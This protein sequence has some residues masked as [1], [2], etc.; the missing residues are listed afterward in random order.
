[1]ADQPFLPLGSEIWPTRLFILRE[2]VFICLMDSWFGLGYPA[3]FLASFLAAT[4]LPFSSEIILSS[5][6]MAGYSLWGCVITASIGNWLGGITSFGLGYL[7]RWE[8]LEK[9]FGIKRERM[10]LFRQRI[11]RY[12]SLLAF[13]TWLPFVGDVLAVALGF[14]R[15]NV[16]RSIAWMLVGKTLRYVVWGLFTHLWI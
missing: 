5:M 4:V 9:Y 6:L 10:E 16:P 12:G 13:F 8:W 7:G 1:M 11:E 2:K 14:F 15:T 3:L